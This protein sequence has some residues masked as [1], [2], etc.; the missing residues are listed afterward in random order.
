MPAKGH[1]YDDTDIAPDC[2]HQGY[3]LHTCSVCGNT[4][5]DNYHHYTCGTET[6]GVGD[7][8][9]NSVRYYYY[10]TSYYILLE[11]G[12]TVEDAIYKM[13][14]NGTPETKSKAINANYELNNYSSSI[15]GYLDNWYKKN[16]TAYTSFLDQ[17]SVYCNDRS[18]RE[19]GG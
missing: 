4:T 10:S 13:T 15:K 12:A 3:T 11:N 5:K 17:T 14:G 18:I 6:A 1:S 19:L 16:L 9:C 8:E 7:T 2:T